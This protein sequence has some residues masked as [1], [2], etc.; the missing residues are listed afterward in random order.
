MATLTRDQMLALLPDNTTGDISAEDMRNI[1]AGVMTLEEDAQMVHTNRSD[2]VDLKAADVLLRDRLTAVEINAPFKPEYHYNVGNPTSITSNE[3]SSIS[4][5][6]TPALPV[7]TYEA[8]LSV[9]AQYDTASRSAFVRFSNDG[10][11]NW[12]ESRKEPKDTTDVIEFT[13]LFIGS[14]TSGIKDFIIE[15]RCEQSGDTLTILAAN[16]IYERKL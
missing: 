14:S 1:I 9:L 2:I 7:G 8:R 13:P 3:Y 16:I 11:I 12:F 4:R 10:G 6:I 15:A 5:L